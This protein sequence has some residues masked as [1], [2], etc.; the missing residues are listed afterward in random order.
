[1][2]RKNILFGVL[3]AFVL[4]NAALSIWLFLRTPKIA[5]VRSTVLVQD[6]YGMKAARSLYDQKVAQWNANLDTLQSRYNRSVNYLTQN[7]NKLSASALQKAREEVVSRESEYNQY[8]NAIEEMAAGENE[9]ITQG[10]L[11]QINSYI[12]QYAEKHKIDLIIG[13]TLSGN[14]LYGTDNLDITEE[15]LKGLNESYK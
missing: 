11:N 14:V 2:L 1:M 10:A 9:I 3:T 6:Y 4:C 13:V 7:K 15:V 12:E 5:Y 8:R